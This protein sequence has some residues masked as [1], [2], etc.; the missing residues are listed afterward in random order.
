MLEFEISKGHHPRT[1][2]LTHLLLN[3]PAS[4]P[5]RRAIFGTTSSIFYVWSRPGVWIDCWVSVEFL[6]APIPRK[7]SGNTTTLNKSFRYSLKSKKIEL[8]Q[9]DGHPRI[10]KKGSLI[11]RFSIALVLPIQLQLQEQSTDHSMGQVKH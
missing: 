7:G 11:Q 8:D 2:Y 1:F 3:C 6:H 4:E 5:L 9:D 10:N